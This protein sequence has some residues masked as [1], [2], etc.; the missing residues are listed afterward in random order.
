MAE[1]GSEAAKEAVQEAADAV[2]KTVVA[3]TNATGE[4]PPH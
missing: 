1:A 3:V 4:A 2:S